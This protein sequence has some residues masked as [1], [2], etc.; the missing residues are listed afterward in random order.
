[1]NGLGCWG[2]FSHTVNPKFAFVLIKQSQETELATSQ[3]KVITEHQGSSGRVTV[4]VGRD[5]EFHGLFCLVAWKDVLFWRYKQGEN[6]SQQLL[7]LPEL[8]GFHL[9]HRISMSD[10]TK[11]LVK[12]AFRGNGRTSACRKRI[13]ARLWPEC[14]GCCQR[15]RLVTAELQL[16]P[17]IVVG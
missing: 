7:N 6:V 11:D 16:L 17:E 4:A 3:Q 13:S 9:R 5:L 8:A 10:L 2:I 1:M 14:P 12:A 15:N